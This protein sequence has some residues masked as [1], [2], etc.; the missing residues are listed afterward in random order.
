MKSL[1]VLLNY[2]MLTWSE[3][4]I[5]S[6]LIFNKVNMAFPQPSKTDW[7]SL[8]HSFKKYLLITYYVLETILDTNKLTK[9]TIPCPIGVYIVKKH[10]LDKG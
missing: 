8:L 3:E 5:N 7:D 4:Y 10:Q 6:T 2:S 1:T 9:Q